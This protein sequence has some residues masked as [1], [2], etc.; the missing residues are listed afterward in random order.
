MNSYYVM[1]KE[2]KAVLKELTYEEYKTCKKFF[3][4]YK[5]LENLLNSLLC[6]NDAV[7]EYRELIKQAEAE[8]LNANINKI[9][10]L[11]IFHV[12]SMVLMLRLFIDNAKSYRKRIGYKESA[13]AINHIEQIDEIKLLK[14]LRNY[15]QHFSIPISNTKIRFSLDEDKSKLDF[16]IKKDEL[17]QNKEYQSNI[18]I[19]NKYAKDEVYFNELVDIW[20]EENKKLFMSLLKDF[21]TNI[22]FKM[23]D[24]FKKYIGVV[25][26][27]GEIYNTNAFLLEEGKQKVTKEIL[28]MDTMLVQL[29]SVSLNDKSNS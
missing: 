2:K 16:T 12:T 17:L 23:K 10:K 7:R 8:K 26:I 13:Q 9:H 27:N 5:L 22:D 15:A 20:E 28:V 24:I 25:E 11:G 6:S 1:D 21:A 18:D 14:A 19:I 3:K 29:I 4:K